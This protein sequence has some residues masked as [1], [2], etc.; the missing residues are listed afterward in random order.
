VGHHLW[1]KNFFLG[2]SGRVF[3]GFLGVSAGICPGIRPGIR[4]GI[5]PGIRPGVSGGG[6]TPRGPSAPTAH[7]SFMTHCRSI[8]TYTPF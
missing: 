6:G 5:C 4:P 1:G 7:D 2:F 3:A 8:I